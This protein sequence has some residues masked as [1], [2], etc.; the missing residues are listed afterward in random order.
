MTKFLAFFQLIPA[1][2]KAVREIED[3]FPIPGIGGN[4]IDLLMG[5]LRT[6]YDAEESI[7]KDIPW[8]TLESVIRNAVALVVGAFKALGVFKGKEQPNA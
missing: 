2:I 4:K 6:F 5:L 3:A 1:I 7:R 8:A